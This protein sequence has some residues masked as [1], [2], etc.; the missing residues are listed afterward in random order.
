M[1]PETPVRKQQANALAG[2]SGVVGDSA[3]GKI[4]QEPGRPSRVGAKATNVR[5]ENITVGTALK[6]VGEAHSSVEAG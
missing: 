6:G 2:P 4:S 5:R 3:R 1:K